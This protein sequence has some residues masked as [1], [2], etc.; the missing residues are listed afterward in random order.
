MSVGGGQWERKAEWQ[1]GQLGQ[2]EPQQKLVG[3]GLGGWASR[4]SEEMSKR[5]K[6]SIKQ[7][8]SNMQLN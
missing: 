4:E 1:L 5:I 6:A 7:E 3:V 8:E 2:V